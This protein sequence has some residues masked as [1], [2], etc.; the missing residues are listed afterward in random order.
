MKISRIL[1]IV[2]ALLSFNLHHAQESATENKL[3]L[4]EG[5]ISS[6]FEYI[7]K[8]SGNYRADGVR[9]EVVKEYNLGK[10]R[11]NVLDSINEFN[12]NINATKI[13]N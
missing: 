11:Q 13:C 1:F 9:Y 2:M 6:Q 10:L 4:D 5:P 8:K 12:N 3:S 7:S